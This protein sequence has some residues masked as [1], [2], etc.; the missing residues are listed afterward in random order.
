MVGV[1]VARALALLA[2]MAT[3]LV[4]ETA[5]DGRQTL[6]GVLFAG[7]ASALFAVLAGVS[8]ALATG[9]ERPRV[10]AGARAGVAV[11]ALLVAAV[12]LLL[13]EPRPADRGD[14]HELR[15]AVPRGPPLLRL[16]PRALLV[17]GGC[18]A[19]LTPLL[20][21]AL[22]SGRAAGPGAQPSLRDVG[23]DP[24]SLLE[25]LLLTG[26]YPVLT[27]TTF[28]LVGLAVGR[29]ALHRADV[30]RRL[31]ALGAGAA[32]VAWGAST[33]LVRAGWTHLV[34]AGPGADVQ[35]SLGPGRLRLRGLYGT[36]P[37]TSPWWLAV[38]APHTGTPFDLVH[39]AGCAVAVLGLCLLLTG[40]LQRPGRRGAGVGAAR[41][42]AATG[43]MTLTLYT[44][45]VI[46]ADAGWGPDEP[47]T[48]W[49]L[50][51]ALAVLLAALWRSWAPRGPLEQVVAE[52]VR[53]RALR[54]PPPRRRVA[55]D[56]VRS[57][58]G[59]LTRVR[60]LAKRPCTYCT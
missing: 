7:R 29:V 57:V 3:H 56:H 13:V 10:D 53:G 45:H 38:V 51:A 47:H 58:C 11:R 12:G 27:W 8:L 2:M 1:D 36:T 31:V 43:S 37:T 46:A 59:R 25:R 40:R 49:L 41:A 52:P 54:R 28:L 42:L 33:L 50:H 39:V 19:V 15:A 60:H 6:T 14:P 44:L 30:A 48:L 17:T 21:H 22:R 4:P 16:R 24:L 26:Y 34:A 55:V 9:G 32:A 23:T 20:S 35:P 5:D 18:W